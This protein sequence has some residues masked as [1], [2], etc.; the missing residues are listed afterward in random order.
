MAANRRTRV[1]PPVERH[2]ARLVDHLVDDRHVAG[3]LHD[4][5]AVVVAAG[6]DRSGEAARDAALGQIEIGVRGRVAGLARAPLGEALLRGR[7]ERRQAA[8]RRIDEQRRL[9]LRLGPFEP[10]LRRRLSP[11]DLTEGDARVLEVEVGEVLIL[12]AGGLRLTLGEFRVGERVARAERLGTLQG[13][14]GRAAAGPLAL[15]DPDRPMAFAARGTVCPLA[16]PAVD[17]V[18]PCA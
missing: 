6:Q 9:A 3:R 11:T 18:G 8:V 7:C 16:R 1:R 12:L 13:N 2:D 5:V 14:G 17:A 10:M 4:R 15:R